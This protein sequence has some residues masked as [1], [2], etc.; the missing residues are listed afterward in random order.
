MKN[1]NIH[2]DQQ[3]SFIDTGEFFFNHIPMSKKIYSSIVCLVFLFCAIY[4]LIF[5]NVSQNQGFFIWEKL[6]VGWI[7]VDSHIPNLSRGEVILSIDNYEYSF[8]RESPFPKLNPSQVYRMTKATGETVLVQPAKS[9]LNQLSRQIILMVILSFV[10]SGMTFYTIWKVKPS[11]ANSGTERKLIWEIL[12]IAAI[13]NII[14]SIS[15]QFGAYH[16]LLAPPYAPHFTW[17]TFILL[18]I[19]A[20]GGLLN[21]PLRFRWVVPL[22]IIMVGMFI[23]EIVTDHPILI[24]PSIT[25]SLLAIMVAV[26]SA[27]IFV[28]IFKKYS[29]NSRQ[30]SVTAFSM[31]MIALFFFI[32][33]Q[34]AFS[35]LLRLAWV[36][37]I[38][39][40]MIH[41]TWP[42]HF[43]FGLFNN[44]FSSQSRLRYIL[45]II[46]ITSFY[47]LSISAL[48]GFGIIELNLQTV[49][50]DML[51]AFVAISSVA[52]ILGAL[53]W[54]SSS[55]KL[56]SILYGDL[57][58]VDQAVNYLMEQ[59]PETVRNGR[60]D[61]LISHLETMLGIQESYLYL[62][63]DQEQK[64][65]PI[66]RA[67]H[68]QQL[69]LS[70]PTPDWTILTLPLRSGSGAVLGYW[71]V[72]SK[73]SNMS[74]Y[75]PWERQ[76][77]REFAQHISTAVEL[78]YLNRALKDKIDENAR[79]ME[80]TL[81]QSKEATIGQVAA[82]YSHELMTPLQTLSTYI[83]ILDESQTAPTET[84]IMQRQVNYMSQVIRS[85]GN[86]ARPS[87]EKIGAID[88]AEVMED[89]IHLTRGHLRKVNA[90]IIS[91]ISKEKKHPPV[92]CSRSHLIQVFTILVVNACD[93]LADISG[94]RE[95]Q[96]TLFPIIDTAIIH[97]QDTG[98]GVPSNLTYDIFDQFFSTKEGGMGLGLSI[99][100]QIVEMHNGTITLLPE[101]NKTIFEI[102]LP[103]AII[104]EEAVDVPDFN[105]R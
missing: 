23:L 60:I 22:L 78:Y 48:F 29:H 77:L 79:L 82:R 89:V 69:K 14:G 17:I 85:T 12:L 75:A 5:F 34:L 73:N 101:G 62:P 27:S 44:E 100:K 20:V 65:P 3:S 88:L 51:L 63:S 80:T 52:V 8:E 59:I 39:V 102:M 26:V 13:T 94:K 7:V 18:L 32:D 42:I 15:I 45:G 64:Y 81:R 91:N 70:A 55:Q 104:E 53:V 21:Y 38:F 84:Q 9:S 105:H 35:Q 57:G 49:N 90:T 97:V 33:K 93:A 37:Q 2:S 11:L 68:S 6:G 76:R 1:K 66:N 87:S 95:I 30:L 47:M 71:M 103:L 46:I 74:S 10:F 58:N 43:S 19:L 83:E 86:F 72:G 98:S 96:I 40:L 99:A 31:I 25:P 54:G 28:T 36:L 41:L 56:S 4:I 67:D 92:Q 24:Q 61:S 50:E 16:Q